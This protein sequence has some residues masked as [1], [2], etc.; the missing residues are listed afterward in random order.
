MEQAMEQNWVM[1]PMEDENGLCLVG[2]NVALSSNAPDPARPA[3]TLVRIP[4]KKPG[5]D[6][7]GDS[8]ERDHIGEMED[9]L[10]ER[11]EKSI[12][13]VHFASVRG[14]GAIAYWT[15]SKGHMDK[16]IRDAATDAFKGYDIECS[17]R[18]DAKWEMYWQLLPDTDTLREV[19]DM[20]LVALLESKGDDLVTP[21]P[22]EHFVVFTAKKSA[23]RFMKAANKQE[24]ETRLGEDGDDGAITVIATRE[25]PVDLE[26]IHEVTGML[27]NLAEVDEGEYDGWETRVVEKKQG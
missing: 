10:A 6:G 3:C 4:F 25:D 24:F 7:M 9:A 8:K 20:H 1:Y 5:D 2:I 13:A 23:E 22:V 27:A 12:G 14:D 16:A 19:A 15:Y 21:R 17:T 11:L 26:T 18:P